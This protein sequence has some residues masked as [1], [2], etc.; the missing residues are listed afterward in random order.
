MVAQVVNRGHIYQVLSVFQAPSLRTAPK[1]RY[2]T[3]EV[4]TA[5]PQI[6]HGA[7][8]AQVR[9]SVTFAILEL[10]W[11]TPLGCAFCLVLLIV[12][13]VLGIRLLA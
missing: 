8:Q 11:I 12:I 2:S 4:A 6:A 13:L 5:A 3:L 1:E 7:N 10:H 9:L